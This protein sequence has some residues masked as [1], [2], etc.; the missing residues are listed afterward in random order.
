MFVYLFGCVGSLQ[1]LG[2]LRSTLFLCTGCPVVAHRLNCP[3]AWGIF[4]SQPGIEPES[5]ALGSRFLITGPL[6]HWTKK[7]LHS[8]FLTFQTPTPTS[9]FIFSWREYLKWVFQPFCW[10]TQF[11]RGLFHVCCCCQLLSRVRLFAT[12]WT[13]AHK[14]LSMGFPRQENW[15]GLPFPSLGDPPHRNRTHVSCTGRQILYHWSHQNMLLN[16]CLIFSC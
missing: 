5:S 11:S 12:P 8:S 7:V 9:S 1:H 2:S 15:S 4:V 6:N 3:S 13:V 10:V 16:F 14:P